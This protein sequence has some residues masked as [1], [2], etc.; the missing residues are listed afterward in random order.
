MESTSYFRR[1]LRVIN[2]GEQASKIDEW[3]L[4]ALPSPK[5]ILGEPGMGK[6]EL[7]REIGCLLKIKP[8]AATRFMHHA[9]PQSFVTEGKPLLIDGLDEAMASRDGDAVDLIF[10][11]LEEAGNPDFMLSCRAREWQS[12]NESKIKQIYDVEPTVLILEALSR[13]EA[14]SFLSHR[15][16]TVDAANVLEHLDANGIADLYSN[17]LTLGLIGRVAESD[18]ELPQTRGVLFDRVCS[19]IWPEHDQDR[20]D[21]GLG[22]LTEEQALSAAGAISAGMLLTG[23]DAVSVA[24]PPQLAEGDIRL[25]DLAALPGAELGKEIL[26]SKLFQTIEVGRA[27]LIHRVIAEFLGARWLAQEAKTGR[28]RRRLLSQLS[29]SGN[30]P[31]SLRGLHAWIAYH[32]VSMANSVITADPFGVLRY[33]DASGL[34]AE[35]AECMLDAL[36]ELAKDDPFFR[37]QDW[38]SHAAAGLMNPK[39]KDKIQK[40]IGSGD[41]NPHLRSLLIVGLQGT[42]M[43]GQLAG[44]LESIAFSVSRFYGERLDALAAL[45]PHRDRTW[46]QSAVE[47]LLDLCTE[48]SI[49]LARD[50]VEKIDCDVPDE[51]LVITLLSCMGLTRRSLPKRKPTRTIS[52]FHYRR[53]G[54]SLPIARLQNVL[55][56][57]TDFSSVLGRSSERGLSNL[58][59]FISVLVIR[60]IEGRLHESVSPAR[61]WAWTRPRV[62]RQH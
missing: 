48:D 55:E 46:C 18:S 8:I 56:I 60:S 49:R 32:S 11:K 35:Q 59:Q 28:A 30:V 21:L 62:L 16:Q 19:L 13:K 47:T 61:L 14:H 15:Y 9:R 31:S 20:N 26:S 57:I 41:S 23:A 3:G 53:F 12:R 38:A 29:G 39:L 37:A 45:I 51:V 22:S 52:L 40:L 2:D 1:H 54:L 24:R 50:L 5:V 34:T 17:P 27:T 25:V 44:T 10:A 42:Q 58:A 33:G 36:N 7:I 43:A 6:S 4:I